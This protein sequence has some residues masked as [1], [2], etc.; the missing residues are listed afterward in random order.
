MIDSCHFLSLAVKRAKIPIHPTVIY[1]DSLDMKCILLLLLVYYLHFRQT[2]IHTV[3]LIFTEAQRLFN[4]F[5]N[6]KWL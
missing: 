5:Q 3:Y 2:E 1:S 6:N 4:L